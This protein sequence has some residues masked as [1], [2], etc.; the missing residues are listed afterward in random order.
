ML[1]TGEEVP[2]FTRRGVKSGEMPDQ[3]DWDVRTAF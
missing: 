1:G 3:E 2:G